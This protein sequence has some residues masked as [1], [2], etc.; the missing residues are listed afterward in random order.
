MGRTLQGESRIGQG[1]QAEQKLL[2]RPTS[3]R[4]VESV[5]KSLSLGSTKIVKKSSKNSN[6]SNAIAS[7]SGQS[8]ASGSEAGAMGVKE[9]L[10]AA[11]NQKDLQKLNLHK[12]DNRTIEEVERDMK[13]RRTGSAH[14]ASPAP[15][16]SS[17]GTKRSASTGTLSNSMAE[18]KR[19][20][21]NS[22]INSGPSTSFYAVTNSSTSSTAGSNSKLGSTSKSAAYTE[23][24]SLPPRPIR[25][26]NNTNKLDLSREIQEIM[27]PGRPSLA[28]NNAGTRTYFKG[29]RG[30]W[31]DED[32]D[33]GSDMEGT[34]DDVMREEEYA[35]VVISLFFPL[36]IPL[37][38]PHCAE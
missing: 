10:K 24:H 2:G 28:A 19:P 34:H 20:R 3:A 12:N 11:F 36:A 35:Y 15:A 32:S 38:P 23:A 30:R 9:R 6:S 26:S 14:S 5:R 7:G 22:A 33:S 18:K 37:H 31:D 27:R 16:A 21:I 4:E 1:R 29:D 17:N 25:P 13:L 8:N